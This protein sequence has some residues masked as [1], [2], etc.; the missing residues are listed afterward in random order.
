MYFFINEYLNTILNKRIRD[1][2]IVLINNMGKQENYYK[3]SGGF[4]Y[5]EWWQSLTFFINNMMN[6]DE[7]QLIL[8]DAYSEYKQKKYGKIMDSEDEIILSQNEK[9]R[10][11]I[12]NEDMDSIRDYFSKIKV[13]Q[14][15]IPFEECCNKTSW[16]NG[17]IVA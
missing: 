14:S 1:S 12:S 15:K 16:N 11:L 3:L 2:T 17:V 6:N 13:G 4:T 8:K 5:D 10:L 7:I 9:I